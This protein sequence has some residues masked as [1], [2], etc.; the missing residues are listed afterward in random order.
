MV[1]INKGSIQFYLCTDISS[2]LHFNE[3]DYEPTVSTVVI[4]FMIIMTCTNCSLTLMRLLLLIA[5]VESNPGP[6][7]GNSHA[8]SWLFITL[9]NNVPYN[10][11]VSEMC[12]LIL[13][14][15]FLVCLTL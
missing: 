15:I 10:F 5:G 13:T 4:L 14:L 1:L 7:L 12:F 3:R 9:C 8:S 6:T 11:A 2:S